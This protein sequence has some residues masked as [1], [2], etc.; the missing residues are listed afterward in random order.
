[1]TKKKS[2]E[3]SNPECRRSLTDRSELQK[4][5]LHLLQGAMIGIGAVLPG[6]SGGVLSVVFG[7]YEP[8]I[9]IF[10][11]PQGGAFTIRQTFASGAPGGSGR[12]FALCA[13]DRIFPD[14]L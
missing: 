10:V 8:I 3:K 12:I 6:I 1:M 11:K 9:G 7:I 5:V 4:F 14:T 13:C 2:V